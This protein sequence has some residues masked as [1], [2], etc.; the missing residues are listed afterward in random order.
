MR[1]ARPAPCTAVP[2]WRPA[3][4]RSPPSPRPPPARAATGPRVTTAF[5]LPGDRVYPEGIALD[6]RTGD[7][8][9]GSFTTGEI[10]RAAAGRRSAEVFLPAG[11]DGRTTANGLK[12]DRAGRLWV[13]DH[14]TGIDVYDPRDRSLLARFGLPDGSGGFLNDLVIT[15][16][17]TVYATDSLRPLI[18]RVTPAETARARGGRLPPHPALRPERQPAAAAVR[19]LRPERHRRRRLR[20]LPVPRRHGGRRPVP[21]GHG[22]RRGPP[23]H[24]ARRRPDPRRRPG[25]ARGHPLG[26]AQRHPHPHP[27]A[28]VPARHHG[29][30]GAP[31]PPPPPS[32]SPPLW[33]ATGA[34]SWSSAPSSTRAARWARACRRRRSR[35]RG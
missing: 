27:L 32:R 1:P 13:I 17:G 22:H 26:R 3:P 2:S 23:G 12:V 25:T 8:Y 35:W 28:P 15:A 9:V 14:T 11:T 24:P 4:P 5:T 19:R 31:P 29:P 20:P 6:R 16:D 30:P 33:S 10:Y 21:G 34:T 7:V 18:Y